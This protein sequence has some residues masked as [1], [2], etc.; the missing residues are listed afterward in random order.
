TV[1]NNGSGPY[2]VGTNLV[3]WTVTDV[4]GNQ[5]TCTQQVIVVDSQAPT[6]THSATNISTSA[7]ARCRAADPIFTAAVGADERAG[8]TVGTNLVVWTVTDVHGNQNTCTQQV[9]VVDSQAPTITQCATNISASANAGCQAAV[10]NFTDAVG[11]SDNCSATTVT[12]SPTIGTLVGLGTNT[13]TITATDV[14]GNFNTCTAS[15]I[16]RDSTAPTITQC[17]TN[18]SAS[19]NASCQ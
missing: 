15:F 8:A 4:H 11:A 18:I 13:V 14:A 3:V 10:P 19:A 2:A 17:A 5:N 12:Q 9:I 7:N 16:V 6:I 1:V